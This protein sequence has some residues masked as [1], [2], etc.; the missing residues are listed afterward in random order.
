VSSAPPQERAPLK[1]ILEEGRE[2]ARL[3]DRRLALGPREGH[4]ERARRLRD[5]VEGYILTRAADLDAPVLVLLLG[6]TGAGKSSLLNTIAGAPVSA[7]GVLRPTT[8]DVVLYATDEDA[9]V[10]LEHGQLRRVPKASV[11]RVPAPPESAQVAVVDAPDI[12]SVEQQNR[13]LADV[14]MESCD[15]CV[16]VTTATRYADLV[17]FE[18]LRRLRE[19][20][21]PLVVV[22]NR[23]PP[24]ERDRELV[25][26]DASRRLAQAGVAID[27]VS[28]VGVREGELD[29]RIDGL[30]RE[31]LRPILDRI[32]QLVEDREERR[33]VVAEAIAGAV[34][35]LA[36]LV[37]AVADDLQHEALDADALRRDASL[38]YAEELDALR[39]ELREGSLLREEILRQWHDF[40]GADQITRFFASGLG[41]LRGIIAE[42]FRG[43]PTAPVPVVEQEAVAALEALALR[44][45]G[46]AARRTASRWSERPDATS[47]VAKDPSLWSASDELAPALRGELAQW[48][49]SIVDD[50]RAAGERKRATA[51]VAALGVN[52]VG[53]AVMLA[54]FAHTA[55]L[56]GAELGVAGG[57]AFLNQKLLEAVFGERVMEELIERARS[58]LDA[59][60]ERLLARER[61]R[62]E[63]AVPPPEEMRD[64]SAGLRSA[65]ARVAA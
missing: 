39:G 34:H 19:R 12:D 25:L 23:L 16:F 64:V 37:H 13:L 62:F 26:A 51:Q 48:M 41:R 40:V 57:T 35:G 10:L 59:A 5:H 4:A 6:P 29:E 45:A 43:R 44:H 63:R 47:Y 30:S 50:V 8:R 42:L 54:V 38:V 20:G 17:P 49:Q 18:V 27:R 52:V 7:T 46:E 14:L 65:V 32:Q 55:G 1:H 24:D 58:R 33:R 56:T 3:A 21:A 36:P 15:L 11:A 53:L 31:P 60:L 61:E 2:L 22:L 9:R 28:V